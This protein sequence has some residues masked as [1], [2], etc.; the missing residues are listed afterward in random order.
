MAALVDDGAGES[1]ATQLRALVRKDL[2][3]P[4]GTGD[5]TFRFD[6]QLI[7][8]AAYDGMAK[9]LRADLHER[10]ADWL[11]A[12]AGVADELLGYHLERAVALRGELGETE[13]TTATLAARASGHLSTA[14]RR[15]AQRDDHA[16]ASALLERAIALVRSD[17]ATRGTLLPALGASLF[18]AG[19]PA[20]AMRVLDE[21]IADAPAPWLEARARVER[22]FVRLEIETSVGIEHA[23]R[24][25]D[26]VLPVLEREGDDHGQ[27]RAWSLRAQA[28]WL[29]GSVERADDAWSEAGACAGRAGDERELFAIVGWRATAAVFG[30]TPVDEAIRR[31]EAFRDVVSASP[32]ALAWAV[33]ALAL[34]HAMSGHFELAEQLL[35]QANATISQL[36]SLHSSVSHI[37]ALVRLLAGEPALA[38]PP[39]R[40]GIET[41]ASMTDRAMLATTTAM[42]AEAVYAQGRLGEADRLCDAAAGAG[43]PDDIVTQVIWRGVKA[44]I[45]AH[46]GRCEEAEALSRAAVALVEPTDLLS[47]QGDA[48]LDLA[49]V[50][51]ACGPS[52][53]Y[54]RAVRTALSLYE[55]K[56]NRPGAARARSLLSN[57]GGET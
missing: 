2:I 39:L 14:G 16:A 23:Q 15:A 38:E 20:D 25:V 52:Q 13:A 50:L 32:V 3:R 27:C 29:A 43:A 21:A 7:R 12:R 36:G 35:E 56:G 48:M 55:R 9:E 24:V 17:Q 19:R 34:L 42:L 33:N 54:Q 41:L 49:E 37:E 4:A 18:E 47:H 53:E 31:C 44:K 51:R 30:P 26:E 57:R 8:D 5:M 1:V 28:S 22:E 46:E 11:Q 40:A 6:H 10:L 45:L